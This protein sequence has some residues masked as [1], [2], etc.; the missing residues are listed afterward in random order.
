MERGRDGIAVGAGVLFL[1]QGS[2]PAKWKPRL[3]PARIEWLVTGQRFIKGCYP[4]RRYALG[5]GS[6]GG[7]TQAISVR[8][9]DIGRGGGRLQRGLSHIL[10]NFIPGCRQASIQVNQF[11]VTSSIVTCGVVTSC[12][13]PSYVVTPSVMTSYFL[14]HNLLSLVGYYPMV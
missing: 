8:K 2:D 7:Y 13:V 14:W 5:L 4:G 9:R 10:A 3:G 11:L 6:R 1:V 12:I